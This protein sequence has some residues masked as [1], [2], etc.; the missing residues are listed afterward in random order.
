[1]PVIWTVFCKR[2]EKIFQKKISFI[3][4]L[5]LPL[6][7][8]TH[9][10]VKVSLLFNAEMYWESLRK[11]LQTG[12]PLLFDRSEGSMTW[13]KAEWQ[14]SCG[15]RHM[16]AALTVR[17]ETSGLLHPPN[18]VCWRT[19]SCVLC[20]EWD[21][22]ICECLFLCHIVSVSCMVLKKKQISLCSDSGCSYTLLE[23]TKKS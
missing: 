5:F 13:S 22:F 3:S 18:S 8:H 2:W 19:K 16:L 15:N 6:N 1:M 11:F 4:C 21:L 17:M 23:S 12:W 14:P 20:Y 7:P 10:P 9:S